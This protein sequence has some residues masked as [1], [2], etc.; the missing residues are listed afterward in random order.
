MQKIT[1]Y[2][3]NM[4]LQKGLK[5]YYEILAVDQENSV[6]KIKDIATDKISYFAPLR[7]NHH[8]NGLFE[9]KHD[10][11][12]LREQLIMT[13]TDKSKGIFAKDKMRVTAIDQIKGLVTLTNQEKQ[14]QVILNQHDLATLHWDYALTTTTFS[15]QGTDKPFAVVAH[16]STSPLASIRS[17]YVGLTRGSRI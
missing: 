9:V 15:S 2:K 10:E 8:F 3:A 13:K 6:L 17:L 12:A 16:K 1:Q 5:N 7:A 11:V 4:V 14:N